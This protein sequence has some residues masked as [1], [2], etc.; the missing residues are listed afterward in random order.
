MQISWPSW[1][2]DFNTN[3]VYDSKTMLSFTTVTVGYF[4]FFCSKIDEDK[5]CLNSTVLKLIH[6]INEKDLNRRKFYESLIIG[7]TF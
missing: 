1:T 6:L 3:A 7:V 4:F 2:L 5:L